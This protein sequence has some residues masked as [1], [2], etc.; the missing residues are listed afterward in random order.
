MPVE[1]EKAGLSCDRRK[2][3][4]QASQYIQMLMKFKSCNSFLSASTCE[5]LDEDTHA[6]QRVGRVSQ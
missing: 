6:L 1:E 4:M 5:M 2:R 3:L